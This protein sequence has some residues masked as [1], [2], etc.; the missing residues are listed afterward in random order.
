MAATSS[1]AEAARVGNF[2]TLAGARLAADVRPWWDA[3]VGWPGLTLVLGVAFVARFVG[4]F[5]GLPQILYPDETKVGEAAR[6]IAASGDLRPEHFN[7]PTFW[8]YVLAVVLKLGTVVAALVGGA[9]LLDRVSLEETYY[10]YATCRAVTAVVCA[11]SVVPLYLVGVRL[12]GALRVPDPRAFALAA[13]GFLALSP[14]HVQ[15]SHVASPDGPTTAFLI[16]ALYFT[17]R[18]VDDGRTRWYLLAGL[19]TGLASGV[20]YPSALF[21]LAIVLAHLARTTGRRWDPRPALVALFDRRLWLAGL[22]TIVSFFATTPYA[23]VE[24]DRFRANMAYETDKQ[25]SRGAVGEVGLVGPF[26]EVRY[27]PAVMHWGLD[28]PVALLALLG[29]GWA[30]W[31]MVRR[32]RGADR[33]SIPPAYLAVL[34]VYPLIVWL[35]SLTW[36]I[37][38]GRYL[39][40]LIP[41]ACLL[42]GLG[43]AWL[44]GRRSVPRAGA[45]AAALAGGSL[46]WQAD[47][48]VRYDHLLSR[49]DTRHIAADWMAANIP[50]RETV[51]TEWYGPPHSRVR[52][53]GFDMSD[54]PLRQH[55][56]RGIRYVATSSFTYNRWLA[57]EDPSRYPKRVAFYRSLDQEGELLFWV[58]PRPDL[59][60]DPAQEG[61]EGWHGI[62]LDPDVRPGP[63]IKVYRLDE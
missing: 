61:W 13:A 54:R 16:V 43:L 14:L 3:L 37:R 29:L 26:A 63:H 28:T 47:G 36:Q 5:Y 30:V 1:A 39:L 12:F 8:L 57:S 32:A 4:L 48:V 25:L 40:P 22:V 31:L 11:L 53:T 38:F 49:P 41:F 35:F 18:I 19:A 52:Q 2:Q 10:V 45:V 7:Y 23:L 55:R 58:A 33:D 42:A 56:E 59:V 20:K 6:A 46:L 62:P 15:H 60:Y 24:W 34:L 21:A 51:L 9:A 44:A 27:A 50:P 17:L